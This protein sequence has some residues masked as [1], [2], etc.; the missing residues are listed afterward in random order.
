MQSN[1]TNIKRDELDYYSCEML[2]MWNLCDVQEKRT[3]KNNFWPSI[4][5]INIERILMNYVS[6]LAIFGLQFCYLFLNWIFLMA[7]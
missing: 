5:I 4:F 3:T 2:F 6:F 7:K 1:Y